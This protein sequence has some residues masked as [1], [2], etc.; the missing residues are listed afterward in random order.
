MRTIKKGA[1]SQSVY[2]EL[3]DSTS[4]TGGRKTGLAFNTA[5]L[6]AYYARSQAAA[7]AIA[8]VTLAS[9]GAA[10][11]SGGFVEVDAT[12]MPGLY[13]LDLPNAALAAGAETVVI[14]L[15]GASGMVQASLA[16]QL[17][18]NLAADVYAR[19]GAPAGPS[20]AADIATVAGYLDTE[21]AAIKAKT[22]NLPSDPADASDIAASFSAVSGTLATIAGYIDTEV[23]A[24]KAKTDQFAFTGGR[25]D[26]SVGAMATN[27]LTAS[28]LAADAV[29]ELA[30]GV[31]DEAISGHLAAGSTGNALNAAG[32][33]GDP[34]S[35]P[36]PGAYGAGTA[37]KIIGD[38]LDAAV[39]SRM[40]SFTYS[41]PLDAAATRAAIG[42]AAANLDVQ[43]GAIAGYID[44]E[45][46]G[47]QSMATAIKAKTDN[48][49]AA[50][51]ASSDIPSANANADALLDRASG[52]EAGWTLRQALRIMLSVLAGK[53]S[54]L[55]TATAH[56]RDMAD[57][58]DR[59]VASVDESGNRTAV[60]R[61]AS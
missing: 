39:S 10:W 58:K 23:A 5:G 2:F 42:L 41:A 49:P 9:A 28:A 59:I 12:N 21:V 24:I 47:L 46:G 45:I 43:L 30:D 14:T 16:I 20:I 1:T 57:S 8:L 33:A 44:T 29:A 22:D 31:W 51:A 25:V 13:R 17:V 35:T 60:T 61:D 37:G 54:G 34:W 55:A 40:A 6:T 48:L 50:P 53:A 52:V 26:A 56:Y 4:T 11:S 36:L 27:V 19:L 18:D 7:A 38:R 15:R 32:S 3:M